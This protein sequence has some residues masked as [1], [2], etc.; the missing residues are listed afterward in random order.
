MTAF[1]NILLS[2]GTTEQPVKA[3]WIYVGGWQ[4]IKVM[5]GVR[6]GNNH[7]ETFGTMPTPSA[8]PSMSLTDESYCAGTSAVNQLRI[9]WT[10]PNDYQIHIQFYTAGVLRETLTY[11]DDATLSHTFT[12]TNGSNVPDADERIVA[13]FYNAMGTGSSFDSTTQPGI[14]SC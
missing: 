7:L 12:R 8:A 11:P 13:Y 5:S 9:D 3:G 1:G 10:N 4:P 2:D 14:L 6:T